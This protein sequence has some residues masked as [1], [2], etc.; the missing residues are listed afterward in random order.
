M[1]LVRERVVAAH[2]APQRDDRQVGRPSTCRKIIAARD[3]T[4]AVHEEPT[5]WRSHFTELQMWNLHRIP[6]TRTISKMR[7]YLG[8]IY[9][10]FLRNDD[11]HL[12]FNGDLVDYQEPKILVAPRWDAD[13]GAAAVTWRKDVDIR[14]ESGRRVSGFVGIRET[15][16]TSDAGLALFYRRKVVTGAGDE[17]YRPPEIFGQGNT[18]ASQRVFGELNMDDFN[19]TYTKDAIVWYDEEEELLELLREHL[20]EGELPILR[21]ANNYRSR[22]VAAAER[23]LGRERG[24][25]HGRSAE[26]CWRS[27]HRRRRTAM[28]TTPTGRPETSGERSATTRC[29]PR[30]C[31]PTATSRSATRA[32]PGW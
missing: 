30:S 23:E 5:D 11:I 9:R 7:G 16:S 6:Q 31:S 1:L 17:S 25:P 32:Q 3:D 27:D 13:A 8:A 20:N 21:Q 15:G 24:Q 28:S 14:L 18:F 2:H 19:V 26:E 12:T 22:V 10:Q 4:L 29:P